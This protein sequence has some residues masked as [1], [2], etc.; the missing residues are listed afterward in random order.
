MTR[1]PQDYCTNTAT[2]ILV[3]CLLWHRSLL[4][5]SNANIA[6]IITTHTLVYW[7]VWH[8]STLVASNKESNSV[9]S[10]YTHNGK[11]FQGCGH[12]IQPNTQHSGKTDTIE[13]WDYVDMQLCNRYIM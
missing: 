1:Y 7:F 11:L 9:T 4:A 3:Y 12:T 13:I 8:C 6:T 5:A 2:V 10:L